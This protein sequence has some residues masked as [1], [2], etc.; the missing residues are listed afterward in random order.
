MNSDKISTGQMSVL[1]DGDKPIWDCIRKKKVP[2]KV[3][4]FTWRLATKALA[5]QQNRCRINM[6]T[7]PTCTICGM[8][9]E[10]RYHA[11]M[12]CTKAVALQSSLKKIWELPKD[13]ELVNSGNEWALIAL[14]KLS[15]NM[16]AKAMP[17]PCYCGGE[18]GI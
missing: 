15:P 1:P 2:E 14:S 5:V 12:R 16:R 4:I 17:K 9:E 18:V 7:D 13:E 3:R 8:E 11:T 10:D 6:T